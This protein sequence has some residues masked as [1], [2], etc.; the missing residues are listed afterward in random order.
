MPYADAGPW[1]TALMSRSH[2][3]ALRPG[4][5]V[6][7]VARSAELSAMTVNRPWAPFSNPSPAPTAGTRASAGP[8]ARRLGALSTGAG[9]VGAPR[10]AVRHDISQGTRPTPH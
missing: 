9:P 10:H 2:S 8:V 7:S 5:V 1:L 6:A 3:P 4:F